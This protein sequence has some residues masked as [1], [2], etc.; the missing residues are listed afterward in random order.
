MNLKALIVEDDPVLQML[1][2][3]AL[4]ALSIDSKIAGTGVEAIQELKNSEFDFVLMDINM[5]EQDGLDAA[6]WIRDERNFQS[7][8]V[9]IFAL[10]SFSSA[11]HTKEII[12][13]G[14]NEHLK[15]PLDPEE[16]KKL[17]EKYFWSRVP[18]H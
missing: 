10:T 3:R 8:D 7:R 16:L 11:E 5:P 14:M 9:L 12:R 18:A 17:L 6:R 13:A 1:H 4:K 15:K 2:Q